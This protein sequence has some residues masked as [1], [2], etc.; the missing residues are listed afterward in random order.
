MKILN[1]LSG[2][3]L[4]WAL[5]IM[6]TTAAG[7]G[8]K[9]P[10][11]GTAEAR[12]GGGRRGVFKAPKMGTAAARV[13]GGRRGW[14]PPK[15]GTAAARVGGGR[16]GW[17]APKLGTAAARVGGGRRGFVA[18]KLGVVEG[19][20]IGGARGESVESD[21]PEDTADSGFAEGAPEVWVLTPASAGLTVSASP[22]LYYYLS[23]NTG[24]ALDVTINLDRLTLFQL[25]VNTPKRKGIYRV[26]LAELGMMLE[27]G[28]E[29][30]WNV[31]LI[32]D[33]A[34][35]SLNITS[36]GV[37]KRV[38]VEKK[39]E[40]MLIEKKS[41]QYEAY[42]ENGIWYEALDELNQKILANPK[43]TKL[44][45]ERSDLLKQVGL[46]SVADMLMQ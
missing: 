16:R 5:F 18:P 36:T 12:V 39:L 1:L 25:Q 33:P 19:G 32:P 24:M 8:F 10:K 4:A 17:A 6:P 41:N 42:A 15:L 23:D 27:E 43:N 37:V 7:V 34:Q 28:K 11:L 31:V 21:V 2:V 40:E 35:G 29:Y 13:G 26:S 30:E 45:T 44:K 20:R 14:A 46:P 9:A 22:S 3:S 38:P